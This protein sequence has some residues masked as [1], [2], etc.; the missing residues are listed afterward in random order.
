MVKIPEREQNLSQ[1]LFIYPNPSSGW[2][3]FEVYEEFAGG[4]MLV[5][6]FQ[7]RLIYSKSHLTK[8]TQEMKI[9][10]SPGIYIINIVKGTQ[11]ISGKL[12]IVRP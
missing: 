10:A 5:Y 7:G 1:Q 6:D 9:L 2:V 4:D 3:N 11:S 8:G 12:L